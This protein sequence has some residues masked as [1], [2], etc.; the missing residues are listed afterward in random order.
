GKIT[1]VSAGTAVITVTSVDGS[2]KKQCTVTVT[3]MTDGILVP[4]REVAL[5]LGDTYSVTPQ[6]VPSTALVKTLKYSVSNKNGLSVKQ[7]KDT[8]FITATKEGTY[9]ITFESKDGKK[10]TTI[11]FI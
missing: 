5:Y 8:Y 11:T 4:N 6:V 10:T 9:N 3:S 7:S 2:Y 1:G